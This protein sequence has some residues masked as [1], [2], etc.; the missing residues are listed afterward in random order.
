MENSEMHTFPK[1]IYAMW[2]AKS[3]AQDFYSSRRVR[4]LYVFVCVSVVVSK[5]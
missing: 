4:F 2:N 3:L 1:D 5:G